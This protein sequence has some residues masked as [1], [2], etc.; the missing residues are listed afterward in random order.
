MQLTSL[1]AATNLVKILTAPFTIF[2]EL[3]AKIDR[4]IEHAKAG[5]KARIIVKLNSL[6]G[7][8]MFT[9]FSCNLPA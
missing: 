5:N 2:D 3:V 6:T 4:E 7:P 9:R 1:T 8:K